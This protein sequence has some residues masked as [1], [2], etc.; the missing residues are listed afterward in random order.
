M[1]ARYFYDV[2]VYR[3]LEERYYA[4]RDAH[5][6]AELEWAGIP[7]GKN[8]A[9]E[10]HILDRYGGPWEFNETVGYIRLYFLGSQV[11]GEWV[12]TR[13]KKIVRSRKNVFW[14]RWHTLAP[15]ADIPS[16]AT[17]EEIFKVILGYVEDCRRALKGRFIDARLLAYVGRHVDWK[18]LY[19]EDWTGTAYSY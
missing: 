7:P 13:A 19:E 3:L 2:P 17:S 8:L 9:L 5:L 1:A 16:G 12:T 18:V 6:K 4:E 14:L 10:E 11:R 15:E